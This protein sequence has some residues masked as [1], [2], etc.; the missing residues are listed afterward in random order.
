MKL[1]LASASL[2][3]KRL[4]SALVGRKKVKCMPAGIG[5]R[6]FR[7]EGFARACRRLALAKANAAAER[8]GAKGAVVVGADTIAYRGRE[9]YRKTGSKNAARQILRRL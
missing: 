2:R 9:I 3:R 5:E 8:K 4:L 7:R 6:I 1:V